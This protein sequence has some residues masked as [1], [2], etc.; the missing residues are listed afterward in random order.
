MRRAAASLALALCLLGCGTKVLPWDRVDLLPDTADGYI[1][2][3]DGNMLIGCWLHVEERSDELIADSTSG[4]AIK[5]GDGT[6]VPAK[7]PPG[8]TGRWV[9]SEV[10]VLDRAGNV[11]ATTGRRYR[12]DWV[13]NAGRQ[14][15]DVICQAVPAQ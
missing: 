1:V 6:I 5:Y 3:P 12:F 14:F 9:G 2:E 7:W 10:E 4:T 13:S 11:V 15:G 8:Y